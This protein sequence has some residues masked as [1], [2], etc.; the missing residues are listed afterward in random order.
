MPKKPPTNTGPTLTTIIHK[1][2]RWYVADCPEIGTVSQGKTI[3]QAIANLKEAT[4]L[5]LEE[6]P[7]QSQS[8][9]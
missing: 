4:D 9:L 3:K 7:K 5:Y 6:F 8:L 2:G 1:E